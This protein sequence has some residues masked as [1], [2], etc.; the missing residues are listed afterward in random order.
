MCLRF[1]ASNL[2]CVDSLTGLPDQIGQLLYKE[3]ERLEKFNSKEY[4]PDSTQKCLLKFATAYPDSL[5][6]SMNLSFKSNQF[7][8]QLKPIIS[9][10]FIKRLD[11]TACNLNQLCNGENESERI[12]LIEILKESAC[13]LEY[14]NLSSNKLDENF[15]K[16][17]TLTQRLG[18][19][20]FIRL[21]CVD[22]SKNYKLKSIDLNKYFNKKYESLNE[23]YISRLKTDEKEVNAK[24][25]HE[26]FRLCECKQLDKN[27]SI[28]NS[29]WISSLPLEKLTSFKIKDHFNPSQEYKNLVK[30]I[31]SGKKISSQ[32]N[33]SFYSKQKQKQQAI[34]TCLAPDELLNTTM[35][36]LFE[37]VVLKRECSCF[38]PS[39]QHVFLSPSVLNKLN[40]LN[41]KINKANKSTKTTINNKSS[42]NN[43][44]QN[45]VID[46]ELL[47]MYR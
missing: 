2:E 44:L 40:N 36:V 17:F 5:I 46:N 7:L 43:Q 42:I 11:L 35:D 25:A 23:I 12:D 31:R 33:L 41:N 37:F 9:V 21:F 18:C 28:K 34:T 1:I 15:V 39:Q 4:S 45:L 29:G 22:L 20:N 3:C 38:A 8:F 32:S 26:S 13:S 47:N 10:C 16:K 19:L 27:Q 24:N 6:E 14:L 30:E